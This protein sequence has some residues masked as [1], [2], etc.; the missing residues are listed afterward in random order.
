[1]NGYNTYGLQLLAFAPSPNWLKSL[2]QGTKCQASSCFIGSKM[3]GHRPQMSKNCCKAIFANLLL[4]MAEESLNWHHDTDALIPDVPYRYPR[5]Q[6]TDRPLGLRRNV[7]VWSWVW[8]SET[9]LMLRK[10]PAKEWRYSMISLYILYT[11]CTIQHNTITALIRIDWWFSI[12]SYSFSI[13][14]LDRYDCHPH[15]SV[16]VWNG[17]FNRHQSSD[18]DRA[19]WSGK[20]PPGTTVDVTDEITYD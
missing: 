8:A 20:Q 16:D 7:K 3:V 12:R 18:I 14:T 1:M 5:A 15:W 6:M 17:C 10:S 19:D 4:D 11:Y 13:P 2:V 9:R